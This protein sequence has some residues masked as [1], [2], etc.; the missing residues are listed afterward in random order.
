LG[1][2]QPTL[3]IGRIG[4]D[5]MMQ[6]H[7]TPVP[8]EELRRHVAAGVSASKVAVPLQTT[9]GAILGRSNRMRVS[10][11]FWTL[12]REEKLRR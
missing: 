8:D 12:E 9:R 6:N 4:D 5:P 10:L 11:G 7:W 2:P 1:T 3:I